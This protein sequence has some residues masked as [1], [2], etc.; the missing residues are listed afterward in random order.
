MVS[1]ENGLASNGKAEFA[2]PSVFP[3]GRIEQFTRL[4]GVGP[5]V[6]T[7]YSVASLPPAD[8]REDWLGRCSHFFPTDDSG[9][10]SVSRKYRIRCM[11][12]P[13]LRPYYSRQFTLPAPSLAFVFSAR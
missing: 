3:P 7:L 10:P 4:F 1:D 5:I 8:R 9:K 13:S 2:D 6:E 11:A 12:F